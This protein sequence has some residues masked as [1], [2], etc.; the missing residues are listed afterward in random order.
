VSFQ[1][2][3]FQ[4]GKNVSDRMPDQDHA[5]RPFFGQD[6]MAWMRLGL[7]EIREAFN[8][9]RESVAQPA[10]YGQIGTPPP[11]TVAR[12]INNQEQGYSLEQLKERG[13]EL[14]NEQDNDRNRGQDHDNSR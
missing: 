1:P 4:K 11:S 14:L 2:R 13:K 5:K 8:P 9:S 7:A 10:Q 6:F 3:F 12:A